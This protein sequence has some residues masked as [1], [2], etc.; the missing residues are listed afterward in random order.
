[1]KI[2]SLSKVT[3][4]S[5]HTLRAWEKRY[6]L[7]GPRRTTTGRRVYSQ[8][9]IQR[10]QLLAKLVSSGHQIGSIADLSNDSLIGM[11]KDL[12]ESTADRGLAVIETLLP[13]LVGYIER[14]NI[15]DF[16]HRMQ[17]ASQEHGSR[18]FILEVIAPLMKH[19]GDLVAK[20]SIDIAQEH[21]VS[22]IIRNFLNKIVFSSVQER[23][24]KP[25]TLNGVVFATQEGDLHEIGILMAAAL[26]VLN[27]VKVY[28]VGPNI[29]AEPLAIAVRAF[30]AKTVVMGY[31]STAIFT[32]KNIQ[33]NY[34]KKLD[35]HLPQRVE[36]YVG[37]ICDINLRL[38][39]QKR[40][41]VHS[42]TLDLFD[43]QIRAQSSRSI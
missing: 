19:I 34:L 29:P 43:K 42:P 7:V 5:V 17:K 9:D 26:T 6:K 2:G 20:G 21:A 28:Y 25:H 39:E 24:S 18:T 27:G 13:E 1:M 36:I 38:F 4:V 30:K 37:G 3:G 31:T 8:A 33:S 12:G 35:A 11:L 15:E 16:S 22:A 14:Y 41:V 40:K 32:Q 10:I 23:V